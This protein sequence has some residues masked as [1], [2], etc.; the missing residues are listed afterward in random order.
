MEIRR[1]TSKTGEDGCYH[2][3]QIG[4]GDRR[5]KKS[6]EFDLDLIWIEI[7]VFKNKIS[8]NELA[9]PVMRSIF[10]VKIMVC[11]FPPGSHPFK[12]AGSAPE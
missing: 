11:S 12:M 5:R 6:N 3:A 9:R 7:G 2:T 4:P 10:L 8:R 1:K